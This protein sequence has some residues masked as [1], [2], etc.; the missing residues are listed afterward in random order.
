MYHNIPL[1]PSEN[2]YLYSMPPFN[3]ENT[4]SN[5]KKL[6]DLFDNLNKSHGSHPSHMSPHPPM[7]SIRNHSTNDYNNDINIRKMNNGQLT[8]PFYPPLMN[9]SPIASPRNPGA[10][11][12]A[13]NGGTPP[14]HPPPNVSLV[15]AP[16][17]PQQ[18]IDLMRP[19]VNRRLDGRPPLSKSEFI[20]QVATMI[21]RDPT[22]WDALYSSYRN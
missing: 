22:F 14:S 9:M 21:Q 13:L 20:Q 2:S 8:K 12:Q 11:L 3:Q 18:V 1:Q 10:L 5:N 4:G 6:Q 15:P 17:M 19:E 7:Q 16:I